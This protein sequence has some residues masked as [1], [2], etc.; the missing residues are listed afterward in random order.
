MLVKVGNE[1]QSQKAPEISET[2]IRAHWPKFDL[3]VERKG[4]A[5]GHETGKRVTV[6]MV[7]MSGICGPVG[8]RIM[9]SDNFYQTRRFGYAVKFADK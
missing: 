4:C 5:I 9:R 3:R 8:I 2:Y 7:S 6:E 1:F